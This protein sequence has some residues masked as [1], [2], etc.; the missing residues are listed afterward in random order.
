MS[1]PICSFI[2][3]C[4]S[5]P[6]MVWCISGSRSCLSFFVEVGAAMIVASTIVPNFS[7]SPRL[8]SRLR[9][10]AKIASVSRCS[11]SRCRKR[12]IVL[13]SGI[14]SSASSIP[15]KRRIGSMS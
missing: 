14:V 5:L 15:A 4:Q 9:T 12:R 3:K 8:S 2:P 13:S 6:F 7:S 1:V 11:S 10:S